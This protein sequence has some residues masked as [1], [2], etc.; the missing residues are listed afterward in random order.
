MDLQEFKKKM[1]REEIEYA[2]DESKAG[3]LVDI[4]VAG[5]PE[6][7]ALY[8]WSTISLLVIVGGLISTF[9]IGGWGVFITIFGFM[10]WRGTKASSGQMIMDRALIDSE[11]FEKLQDEKVLTIRNKNE[12]A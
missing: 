6:R 9:W 4:G 11:L 12:R 2:I 5:G 3:L 1:E 7:A 10:T 8:F